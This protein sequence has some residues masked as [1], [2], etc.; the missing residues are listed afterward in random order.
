M[1]HRDA[2]M[3][4]MQR[5]PVSVRRITPAMLHNANL[6]F[7]KKSPKNEA[8]IATTTFNV[9]AMTCGNGYLTNKYIEMLLGYEKKFN[10]TIEVLNTFCDV[11]LIYF[12]L[13]KSQIQIIMITPYVGQAVMQVSY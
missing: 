1:T 11:Y 3:V 13:L 4:T 9:A 8:N 10:G 7:N 12:Y 5:H 6:V 2:V